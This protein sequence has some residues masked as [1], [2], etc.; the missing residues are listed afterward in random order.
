MQILLDVIVPVFMIVGFGYISVWQNYFDENLIDALLKFTQNFAIPVLLFKAMSEVDL[1]QTFDP[2]LLIAF[3]TGASSGFFLG[4]SSARYIFGKDWQDCV[5]IGFC[6]LF[7]NSLMLGLAI[8]ER[9]YGTDA[10]NANFAIVT[11]HA[12]FCYG[13]GITMMEIIRNKGKKTVQMAKN[14]LEAMFKNALVLGILA[15]FFVN[16][17]KIQLPGSFQTAVDMI[18]AISLTTALFGMG[19][20]LYRYKPKGD[21]GIL[22]MIILVS[23]IVHPSIVWSLGKTFTLDLPSFRSAVITSAMAPGIN[24]YIFANMYSRA[25]RIAASSVLLTTGASFFTVWWW[26]AVLP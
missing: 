3:Y 19:G 22:V 10:L 11:L 20:V 12:P 25:R 7:S 9:A 18:A 23:L 1:A 13:L 24:A 17:V 8:T 15:G 16:F 4:F 21:F 26:L 2:K 5:T 6:C 14:V